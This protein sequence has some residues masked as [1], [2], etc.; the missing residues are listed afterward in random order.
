M[1]AYAVQKLKHSLNTEVTRR[2]LIKY[3]VSK[4]FSDSFDRLMYPATIQDM[5]YVIPELFTK[6]EV[7]PHAASV[8]PMTDSAKIGWNLF[9]LGEKRMFLG[10]TYHSGLTHLA[11]MIMSGQVV[12][13]SSDATKQ[14]T[15]RRIIHFITNVLRGVE[16]GYVDLTPKM[17][18]NMFQDSM[19]SRM[20]NNMGMSSQYFSRSGYGT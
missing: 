5:Q 20:G 9:V 13:E 1:D 18:P 19:S 11:Q 7:V 12:A 15:P 3:F 4:G 6:L 8:D 14:T 17:I 10:E 2:L 16:G